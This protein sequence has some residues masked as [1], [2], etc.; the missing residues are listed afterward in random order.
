MKLPEWK[1]NTEEQDIELLKEVLPQISGELR[2]YIKGASE[3]LLYAQEGFHTP[4]AK[5]KPCGIFV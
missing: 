1:V 3:A 5:D 4:E 2:A